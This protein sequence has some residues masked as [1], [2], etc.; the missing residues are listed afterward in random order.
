LAPGATATRTTWVLFTLPQALITT[1]DA[2][3]ERT[4]STP[5]DPNP[6]NDSASVTCWTDRDP[7]VF[8][9]FPYR[10]YC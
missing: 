9:P 3:A 2:T 8:P 4:A 7:T 1:L 5:A 6:A 10:V